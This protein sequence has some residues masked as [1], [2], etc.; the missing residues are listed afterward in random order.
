MG[1]GEQHPHCV[2]AQLYIVHEPTVLVGSTVGCELCGYISTFNHHTFEWTK[3]QSMPLSYLYLSAA[4]ILFNC[5]VRWAFTPFNNIIKWILLFFKSSVC[6][7]AWGCV[8][9]VLRMFICVAS[10]RFNFHYCSTRRFSLVF[11]WSKHVCAFFSFKYFAGKRRA[12]PS[13]NGENGEKRRRK[14]YN[15]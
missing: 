10:V 13:Q 12:L 1:I 3:R 7:C 9:W 4:H 15:Y 5:F 6:V 14:I 8:C 11:P 2:C